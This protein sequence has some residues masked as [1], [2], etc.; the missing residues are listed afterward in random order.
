MTVSKDAQKRL[1]MYSVIAGALTAG[2][3][4]GAVI[5]SPNFP[6][7]LEDTTNDFS[8]VS[9]NFDIDDD[10]QDDFYLSVNFR[11]DCSSNGFGSAYLSALN[12]GSIEQT[13]YYAG[14]IAPG[15]VIPGTL[16][17][18]GNYAHLL[19]CSDGPGNFVP[20][21]RGYVAVSFMVGGAEH[22]GYL[23][24]ETYEGSLG[25]TIHNAYY[26]ST[27]RADITVRGRTA[28]IPVGGAIPLTLGLL[29]TGAV[30]LRRRRN[31]H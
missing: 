19:G 20:P 4:Q 12:G 14:M 11:T 21:E 24:V 18:N 22:F 16:D 26:E 5:Q 15:T 25:V 29:A 28:G 23:D 27:P 10:G 3:A 13:N 9:T 17:M 30:A 7:N 31:Q 2:A 8:S 1:A 6:V